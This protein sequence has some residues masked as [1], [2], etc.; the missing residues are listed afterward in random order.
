TL[1]GIGRVDVFAQGQNLGIRQV[2]HTT[3]L[4]D[5]D[6]FADG[7]GRAGANSGDIGQGNHNPLCRGDV[8]AGDTCQE[9][10]SFSLRVRSARPFFHNASPRRSLPRPAYPEMM[11]DRGG[12]P[13]SCDSLSG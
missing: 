9:V 12:D 5:T 11:T 4:I 6:R 2:V 8:Y 3:G 10:L 1:D 13:K 7:L